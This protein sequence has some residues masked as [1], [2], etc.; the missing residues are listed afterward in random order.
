MVEYVL[1]LR[2]AY[3]ISKERISLNWNG[4]EPALRTFCRE[5]ERV[6]AEESGAVLEDRNRLLA[7]TD[8]LLAAIRKHRDQ[9]GDDRCWLDDRELYTALPE[10]LDGADLRLHCP[11]EMLA[12]CKRYI[13]ARHDPSQ[14]YV[15]P[16]REIEALRSRV[17]ELEKQ[18]AGLLETIEV[19]QQNARE[20]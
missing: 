3:N 17:A 8:K 14:E 7:L 5:L 10:G 1:R 16:Q 20:R 15:S 12:N 13:A 11:E 4:Q 9:R 18:N 2:M 6:I 19:W